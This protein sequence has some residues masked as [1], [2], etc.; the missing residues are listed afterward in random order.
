MQRDI[1]V[2]KT[3]L[4]DLENSYICLMKQEVKVPGVNVIV[5]NAHWD[6]LIAGGLIGSPANNNHFTLT[7]AGHDFLDSLRNNRLINEA[8][9][10]SV[11]K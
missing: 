3:I 4:E 10:A 1:R 11:R 6:M 7:W 5:L 9:I 2:I 8:I